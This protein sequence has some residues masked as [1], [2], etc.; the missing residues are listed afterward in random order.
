MPLSGG[1]ANKLGNFYEALWTVRALL[2]ILAE[3]DGY[4]TI[5][6]EPLGQGGA[7][8]E[9]EIASGSGSTQVHQVKRT[10]DKGWTTA[11][12][13]AEGVLDHFKNHL[14]RSESV[15]CFFVSQQTPIKL[16]ELTENARHSESFENFTKHFLSTKKRR[17]DFNEL[18]RAWNLQSDQEAFKFLLRMSFEG[19]TQ[20]TL[21]SVLNGQA[22]ELYEE[23]PTSIVDALRSLVEDSIHRKLDAQ[24]IRYYLEVER[25]FKPRRI[26]NSPR[27]LEI[28]ANQNESFLVER[29]RQRI[30]EQQIVREE[31]DQVIDYFESSD[32]LKLQIVHGSAGSGK[33]EILAQVLERLISSGSVVLAF[34]LDKLDFQKPSTRHIGEFLSLPGSPIKTLGELVTDQPATI[35]ID[36]LDAV[37]SVSGRNSSFYDCILDLFDEAKKYPN[38]RLVLACRTFDLNNDDRFMKLVQSQTAVAHQVEISRL[39]KEHVFEILKLKE[40]DPATYSE[41][42]INLLT[43]PLN[44]KVFTDAGCPREFNTDFDLFQLYWKD[45]KLRLKK[46]TPVKELN[47][48]LDKLL[49][50]MI[51]KVLLAV[52]SIHFAEIY[53][54]AVN[55][56]LTEGVL[57][58]TGPNVAFFHES[59]FDYLFARGFVAKEEN[60]LS[61]FLK[62]QEQH[63][64]LRGIVRQVLTHQLASVPDT[65]RLSLRELLFDDQIRFHIK[66]LVF[67]WMA[68][69]PEPEVEDWEMLQKLKNGEDKYLALWADSAIN[70]PQWFKF[71]DESGWVKQELD[72]G[73]SSREEFAVN[74]LFRMMDH[75]PDRIAEIADSWID[76]PA[77]WPDY[78]WKLIGWS[79]RKP[80][81]K[82]VDIYIKL[83]SRNVEGSQYCPFDSGGEMRLYHLP[84]QNP[85]W[86]IEILSEWLIHKLRQ[87]E[88]K[89]EI[90]PFSYRSKFRNEFRVQH[91]ELD[92]M[93]DGAPVEFVSRILP[94]VLELA[95]R[96]AVRCGPPPWP[97]EV[98]TGMTFNHHYELHDQLMFSLVKSLCQLAETNPATF[99]EFEGVLLQFSD[100]RT[101]NWILAQAYAANGQEFH[102]EGVELL[103]SSQE[104]LCLGW[105]DS[106]FW[107]SRDLIRAATPHCSIDSLLRIE[108]QVLDFY[109]E[110]ERSGRY[111][112]D[113]QLTLLTGFDPSR[114]STR[115]QKRLQELHR[116]F[117]N[118]NE[119]S[120]RPQ[121]IRGGFVGPPFNAN[122]EQMS[123]HA[124]LSAMR[125]YPQD[126]GPREFL[127][128]GAYQLSGPLK[129][130]ASKEPDRFAKL[131]CLIPST[132]DTIYP[133]SI[134]N[135]L[136]KAIEDKALPNPDAQLL[137]SAIRCAD[138][139]PGR[140]LGRS[141]CSLIEKCA[142]F[143]L[144]ADIVQCLSWYATE[145]SDPGE[146]RDTD[147]SGDVSM[148]GLNSVRGGA[149]W[150]LAKVLWKGKDYYE[151]LQQTLSKVVRDPSVAVRSQAVYPLLPLLNYD[152]DEA[153]RLFL[154]IM[155]DDHPGL[156]KSNFTSSFLS[157]A[158]WTHFANLEASLVRMIS[159]ED[160]RVVEQGA[161]LLFGIAARVPEAKVYAGICLK[162]CQ[163]QRKGVAQAACQGLK[164]KDDK[165]RCEEALVLLFSD[166]DKEVRRVASE[167]FRDM[168]A[169]DIENGSQLFDAFIESPSFSENSLFFFDLLEKVP[170]QMPDV[171]IKA[172]EKSAEILRDMD[173]ADHFRLGRF[174]SWNPALLTRLYERT[175]DPEVKRR[176]LDII[177]DLARSQAAYNLDQHLLEKFR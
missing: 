138:S 87:F 12:L 156:L 119:D 68:T 142:E 128:G 75:F 34:R 122:W 23:D 77:P 84:E 137:W 19:M 71:L 107:I 153:V 56:L 31:A 121:G 58:E 10:H 46:L 125:D 168:K 143:D 59:F 163:A 33:S 89:G 159:A 72:S 113:A 29:R 41:P 36:Q 111:M 116:K 1:A 25:G 80:S 18:K 27:L 57:V 39:T 30:A 161:M 88:A 104:S 147:W 139:I 5:T 136:Q 164:Y 67:Q 134:L 131:I 9:F 101:S 40:A 165:E 112:G 16:L 79:F 176:C 150:A 130:A 43:L 170:A 51:S 96:N 49:E 174:T 83:L 100:F 152:R 114:L 90:N 173:P 105:S 140:P 62:N 144:P 146:Y 172:F 69:L 82:I 26:L 74:Y 63:L 65:C 73:E 4:K 7:G 60:K 52:P 117:P 14:E 45:K 35:L 70:S 38:L 160:G 175:S 21:I 157:Y 44:L 50:S 151:Q 148:A 167:C 85:E 102:H 97:D 42:Q 154:T 24:A 118:W 66:R 22:R 98:W 129:E 47:E 6:L 81:R 124:W 8:V 177:D 17:S 91:I 145:D 48:L 55:A 127:K 171:I 162:G 103:T 78:A 54:E 2:R 20:D 13:R 155:E 86:A 28:I 3:E 149:Q 106:S 64:F 133:S 11:T 15:R 132:V 93:A 169:S 166:P 61:V 53:G 108:E 126:S 32:S 158:I 99:R 94:I 95:R 92:K 76:K 123:D 110:Y 37:S 141:I 135:G 109:P 120:N 115:A